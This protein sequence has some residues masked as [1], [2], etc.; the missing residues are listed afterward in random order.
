MAPCGGD[1]EF[2]TPKEGMDTGRCGEIWGDL[3]RDGGMRGDVGRCGEMWGDVGRSAR[4]RLAELSAAAEQVVQ[5][6]A[7]AKVHHVVE[8]NKK[9][10]EARAHCGE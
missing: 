3:G 8:L 2:V 4:L 6:A 5:V 10:S 9:K 1:R 7:V